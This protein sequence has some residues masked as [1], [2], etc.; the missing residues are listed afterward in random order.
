MKSLFNH[1]FIGK[2]YKVNDV[3]KYLTEKSTVLEHNSESHYIRFERNK[4]N[5]IFFYRDFNGDTFIA[6]AFD[7]GEMY[8]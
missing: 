2:K 4:E 3:L 6:C 5:Y 7:K 8:K 1:F